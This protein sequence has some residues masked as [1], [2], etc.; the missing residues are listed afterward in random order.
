MLPTHRHYFTYGY[1][2]PSN[3]KSRSSMMEAHDL[4]T[5]MIIEELNFHHLSTYMSEF[6]Y[7]ITRVRIYWTTISMEFACIRVHSGTIVLRC[8]TTFEALLQH[9]ARI[10]KQCWD[11]VGSIL[12]P[13]RRQ[14]G[15]MLGLCRDHFGTILE[16]F[17]EHSGRIIEPFGDHSGI[18]LGPF[19]NNF[20]SILGPCRQA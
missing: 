3:A 6:H 10:L 16:S 20:G 18:M 12:K 11:H 19:W 2:K 13:F 15:S 7:I 17:W 14:C 5:L 8:S 4:I 9:F 1:W